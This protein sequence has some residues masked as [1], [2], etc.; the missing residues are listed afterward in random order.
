LQGQ[1][2]LVSD[3]LQLEMAPVLSTKRGLVHA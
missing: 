2:R 3:T 1:T